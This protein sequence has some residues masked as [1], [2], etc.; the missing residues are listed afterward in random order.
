[1]NGADSQA[2]H[3]GSPLPDRSVPGWLA[4]G[5]GFLLLGFAI[6]AVVITAWLDWNLVWMGFLH[7]GPDLSVSTALPVFALTP[8][9]GIMAASALAPLAVFTGAIVMAALIRVLG[10]LPFWTVI[11]VIPLC[12]FAFELQSHLLRGE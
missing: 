4:A 1:M 8:I 3:P 6:N 7:H 9:A 2:D 5:A 11:L 12:I 10:S